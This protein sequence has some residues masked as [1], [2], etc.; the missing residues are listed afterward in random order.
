MLS[1]R[2]SACLECK[3]IAK[4]RFRS[5]IDLLKMQQAFEFMIECKS[6]RPQTAR[7]VALFAEF[8]D[9]ETAPSSSAP[10]LSVPE[11]L[12]SPTPF[13]ASRSA[14]AFF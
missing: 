2:E 5:H 9:E 10:S 7:R 13:S 11:S 14:Q 12:T 4:H 6:Q 8:R 1:D 3:G